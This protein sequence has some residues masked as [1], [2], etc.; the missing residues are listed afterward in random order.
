MLFFVFFLL[1]YCR[2]DFGICKPGFSIEIFWSTGK[3]MGGIHCC[4]QFPELFWLYVH[5]QSCHC[6]RAFTK[7]ELDL[8]PQLHFFIQVLQ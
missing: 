4:R 7:E 5:V 6:F 8:V 3:K 1:F 2:C